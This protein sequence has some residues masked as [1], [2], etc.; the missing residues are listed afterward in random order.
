MSW[1]LAFKTLEKDLL[2]DWTIRRGIRRLLASRIELHARGDIEEQQED[3]REFVRGLRASPIAVET[4]AAND[5]HYEVP[6]EFFELVLGTHLKYSSGY[7]HPQ[8]TD[9]S[10]A[11]R[12]MLDL[13]AQRAQLEDGQDV[14]DLGCGWGS[15]SLWLAKQHPRSRV[16]AVS[17]SSPQRVFIEEQILRYNLKNLEVVTADINRF[18]P[19]RRFDRVVSIEMF[20]HM[21]NYAR[22]MKNVA[23]WLRPEGLLFVHIFAH[24][25]FAYPF[26]TTDEDDWMGR[27][28]FTGGTMPSKDLLLR[29]QD[30]VVLSD[31][32]SVSGTHYQRTAEAWL[33]NLDRN[34]ARI[35]EI[36]EATY[37]R[38]HTT[39]WIVRWRTFFM[40]C[41]ELWGFR[42]GNEWLVSHYLFRPRAAA[43]AA[44]S[45]QRELATE[46][47]S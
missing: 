9:L 26:E 8:V 39:R 33:D 38:E 7:W 18:D 35:E 15:L 21:K 22:L 1:S 5:Q 28:F 23:G 30:D 24:K 2:P 4:A 10:D 12:A 46:Q 6:P 25:S 40:A 37:G 43:V 3:L 41:A 47:V 20:E 31:E 44:A 14:L 11:E 13:Y 36:F 32:W 34:R 42:G 29:F 16:L 45:E 19:G 17:N 27:H